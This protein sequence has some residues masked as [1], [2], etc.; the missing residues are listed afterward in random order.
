MYIYSLINSA[1]F[2]LNHI[3]SSILCGGD[4]NFHVLL[5]E[6]K[7]ICCDWDLFSCNFS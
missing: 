3:K 5:P 4:V 1:S 7:S 6:G 2:P